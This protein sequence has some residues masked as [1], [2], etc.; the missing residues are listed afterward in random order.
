MKPGMIPYS[1]NAPFWSDGAHKERFLAVPEGTITFK[2][3]NGWDF[4]D[5]TVLVKSFALDMKEGDPTSRKWIE[6]RFLTRQGGEWYGYSYKWNADGTDATLV[7]A[8]GVDAVYKIAT[9]AGA[10]DQVW[11]YPSR[12][13]CMVCHS[14]AA[15]YVLGLCEVQMNRDHTYPT[16]RTDNQLRVL[17]RVGLLSVNWAGEAGA[18]KQQPDQ[19]EPKP[20][21]MLHVPPAALKKLADPYDP[22]EELARV[23]RR[24][25]TRTARRVTSRRAAGTRRWNWA[26][27]PGGTRCG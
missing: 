24:G 26:T 9:G 16:G 14:R 7:G 25:C 23:R 12:A 6:T 19:R 13:E 22:K 1:V 4:P 11:H 5:K 21:A 8:G 18:A 27:R 2:R 15:N 17:E 10:V 20:S 3:N